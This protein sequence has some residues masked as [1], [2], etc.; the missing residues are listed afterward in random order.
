M[1]MPMPMPTLEQK[2]RQPQLMVRSVDELAL[3]WAARAV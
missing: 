2:M 3:N 1:P